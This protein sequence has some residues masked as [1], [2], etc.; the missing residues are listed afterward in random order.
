MWIR[1]VLFGTI[2]LIYIFFRF[3][4]IQRKKTNINGIEY[5]LNFGKVN[6]P[7]GPILNK[8][9]WNSNEKSVAFVFSWSA[10]TVAPTIEWKS[11]G[12]WFYKGKSSL[13]HTKGNSLCFAFMNFAIAVLHLHFGV[14]WVV[15]NS[16]WKTAVW[17]ITSISAQARTHF[18]FS[19]PTDDGK[20]GSLYWWIGAEH[21]INEFNTILTENGTPRILLANRANT[22]S[23]WTF[24]NW[25]CE[26]TECDEWIAS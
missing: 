14:W 6:R 26:H 13:F 22:D 3:V 8:D 17:L 5:R 11:G 25:I 1:C 23:N 15:E 4:W 10:A 20:F 16:R 19:I 12:S 21:T 7:T 24:Q 9:R 2:Y 18:T